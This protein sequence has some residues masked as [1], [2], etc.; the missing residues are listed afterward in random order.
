MNIFGHEET[1]E[2]KK[3]D[4]EMKNPTASLEE[5]ARCGIRR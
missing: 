5:R 1:P 4:V 3:G 2:L